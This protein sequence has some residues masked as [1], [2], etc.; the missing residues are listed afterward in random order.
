[1]PRTARKVAY[2]RQ[3]AR[4]ITLERL[5]PVYRRR[6]I[7][8]LAACLVDG[9]RVRRDWFAMLDDDELTQ[10]LQLATK[11]AAR[12]RW[13]RIMAAIAAVPLRLL[14]AC[15]R[16]VGFIIRSGPGSDQN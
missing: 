2:A 10:V 1:M 9:L 6:I 16:A 7:G 12:R 3:R 5:G 13:R 14:E 11:L 4:T 15:H 8:A